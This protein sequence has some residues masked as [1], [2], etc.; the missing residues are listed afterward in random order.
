MN[1]CV[2]WIRE[3]SHTD[4]MSQGYVG[5][6]GNVEKRFAS[7]KG[8]WSGTNTHLR[9]AIKKY[10]WDNL[11]KSIIL[12]AEKEYCLDI[13]RELRP[14]DKIGWNLTAGGG[15]PPTLRGPQPQWR[16]RTAWNK[17]KTGVYS[18]EVISAMRER[19]LGK[20]PGNKGVPM[21]AEQRAKVS[22]AQKGKISPLRNTKRPLKIVEKIAAKNRGRVQSAEERAMRSERMKGIPKSVPRSDE[23]KRKLGLSSKGKKWF[24]N[25]IDSVFC[26]P[27]NKPDGFVVGRIT[28]WLIKK[29]K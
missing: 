21:T 19:M 12:V 8:M 4:L 14:D 2:Y 18:P 22:A 15:Y 26:L 28:P 5:V 16:G 29:E 7:H 27:D 9:R 17:G 25:G 6:S 24:N 20:E 1:F 13:E 3:K 11:V 23:H 10:G